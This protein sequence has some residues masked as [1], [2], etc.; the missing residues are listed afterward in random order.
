MKGFVQSSQVIRVIS[1]SK[2]YSKRP[3]DILEIEDSYLAF[4]FDEACLY[5][6]SMLSQKD[7]EDNFVNKPKWIDDD[8]K[9]EKQNNNRSAIE[10]MQSH[11]K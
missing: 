8:V 4:C 1:Q 7:K 9:T 11:S 10:W 2:I 3:S 6:Q 5:I